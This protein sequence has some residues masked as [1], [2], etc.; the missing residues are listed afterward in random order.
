MLP[1]SGQLAV[2][3][4]DREIFAIGAKNAGMI[5]EYVQGIRVTNGYS[6][7]CSKM[8]KRCCREMEIADAAKMP[9]V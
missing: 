4:S 6:R 2:I 3:E 1:Q 5:I 7:H 8:F 9:F